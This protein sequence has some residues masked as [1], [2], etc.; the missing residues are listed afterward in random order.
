MISAPL[1]FSHLWTVENWFQQIWTV[2]SKTE[3]CFEHCSI[4]ASNCWAYCS[5]HQSLH[6]Q[7]NQEYLL[8]YCH[9][10]IISLMPWQPLVFCPTDDSLCTA[11]V[12][13]PTRN[14]NFDWISSFEKCRFRNHKKSRCVS[15]RNYV[16]RRPSLIRARVQCAKISAMVL[17]WLRN[18]KTLWGIVVRCA[19]SMFQ[20]I[21][22]HT[23]IYND[24][25]IYCC[26][27]NVR[28][29][30]SAC[31]IQVGPFGMSSTFARSSHT[32]RSKYP[33]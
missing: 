9:F 17:L 2:A 21:H 27:N 28:D 31:L 26:P 7:C 15:F 30:I 6:I 29:V 33:G 18:S 1:G 8:R 24:I 3:R 20:L 16:R 10:V 32:V 12:G 19:L 14:L 4:R 11:L 5:K 22:A 23:Q 13:K 25:Y